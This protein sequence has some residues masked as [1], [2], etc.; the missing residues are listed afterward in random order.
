M[1]A[2]ANSKLR[3]LFLANRVPF[4]ITDGQGRR[5]YHILKGLAE[6][7]DVHLLS[8]YESADEGSAE[9]R[10]HLETFCASVELFPAPRK[11]LSLQMA[12][13]V[14]A[15]LFSRDPYTVWRHYS[16]PFAAAVRRRLDDTSFDVIHCD[17]LPILYVLRGVDHGAFRALTDHDVSYLKAERRRNQSGLALTRLFHRYEAAKLKRM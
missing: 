8:M 2:P 7:H 12:V 17:I 10:A 16:R 3:I 4:P 13:R 1:N 14:A 5:T 11:S 15:S 6:V 9:T